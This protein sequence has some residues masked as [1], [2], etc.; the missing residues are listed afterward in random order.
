MQSRSET[1]VNC[2]RWIFHWNKAWNPIF[3]QFVFFPFISK[4]LLFNEAYS[5]GSIPS[6]GGDAATGFILKQEWI[7][8]PLLRVS[9]GAWN[10]LSRHE[11][12]QE[13]VT[14]RTRDVMACPFRNEAKNMLDRFLY[15]VARD[16]LIVYM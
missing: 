1:V 6:I 12:M 7:R 16:G 8:R 4:E 11:N 5:A 3:L 14:T 9:P 15:L 13:A 10:R 2:C